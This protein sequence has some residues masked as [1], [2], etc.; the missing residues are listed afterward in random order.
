MRS[1]LIIILLSAC[2]SSLK[3]DIFYKVARECGS[4]TKS[5]CTVILKEVT[6]FQWDK[7][8]L[9]GSWTVP[10]SVSKMIGFKY[11]GDEVPDDYRR[12]VFTFANRVVYQE[13]FKPFDYYSSTL[14]FAVDGDSL[15]S[16]MTPYFTP[17]DA[18]FKVEKSK[19][20]SNC[21]DCFAYSLIPVK[22]PL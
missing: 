8:Y 7:M 10:D 17:E 9:F 5:K 4:T 13:D 11:D 12:M 14:I 18:I 21:K 16:Q 3:G 22:R 19:I 1:L 15:R 6:K 20:K 2:K